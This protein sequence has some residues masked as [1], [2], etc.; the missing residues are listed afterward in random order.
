MKKIHIEWLDC[1]DCHDGGEVHV[2]TERGNKEFVY[3]DDHI[4][5]VKCEAQGY[6]TVDDNV[7]TPNWDKE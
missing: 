1:F 5:C 7:A 6:I 4:E 3:E 2:H